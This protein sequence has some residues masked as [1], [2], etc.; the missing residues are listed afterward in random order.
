MNNNLEV[1]MKE[2]VE[3]VLDKIRPSLMADGG[4]VELVDVEAGTV[5]VRLTGACGGC[6]MSQM[7]LKMGIERLLKKELPEIKE[8]VSV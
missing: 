8:V 5:K 7:T 4:N 6:P 2:K 3:K 1:N